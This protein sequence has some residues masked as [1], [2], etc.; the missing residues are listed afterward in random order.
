MEAPKDSFAKI[1]PKKA[2]FSLFLIVLNNGNI[3]EL[4]LCDLGIVLIG[5]DS[6]ELT[7]RSDFLGS[8]HYASFEQL[9]GQKPLDGRTDIYSAGS[10]LY[11]CLTGEPPYVNIGPSPAISVKMREEPEKLDYRSNHSGSPKDVGE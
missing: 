9:T 5:E 7:M 8:K 1:T 11:H 4:K 2:A 10:V 6:L 3:D